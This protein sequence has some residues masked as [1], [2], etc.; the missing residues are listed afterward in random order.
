M[1]DNKTT[2][3]GIGLTGATFIVFLVLKL[4]DTID[5]SWWWVTS[6][7]WGAPSII[8]AVIIVYY[9]VVWF[10]RLATWKRYLKYKE[11][12]RQ[13]L[14]ERGA[15]KY[16][17]GKDAGRKESVEQIIEDHP[18]PKKSKFQQRLEEMKTKRDNG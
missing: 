5:W 6:P 2:S 7:L 18:A 14:N 16:S 12:L 17:Y 10:Y 15:L 8:V 1:S 4:T 3:G 9:S 13:G 11:L